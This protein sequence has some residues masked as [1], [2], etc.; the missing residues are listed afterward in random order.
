MGPLS[1]HLMRPFTTCPQVPTLRVPV[2]TS[3]T[4]SAVALLSPRHETPG[5]TYAS[6]VDIELYR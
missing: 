3:S 5:R 4:D 2:I 1:K 6:S